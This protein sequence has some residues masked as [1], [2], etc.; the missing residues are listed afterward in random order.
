MPKSLSVVILK[1]LSSIAFN[2]CTPVSAQ[3]DT[4]TF[5]IPPYEIKEVEVIGKKNPDGFPE[6]GRMVTVIRRE[7][8]IAAPVQSLQ[9]LLESLFAVDIC[10]R[11]Q[12]G[13]QADLTIRGGSFDHVMILLNGVVIS[14][15]QTGHFNLDI[16]LDIDAIQRIE[17]LNGPS[18]RIYGSGALTGAI[19]II[20][21]PGPD[22]YG[23][24]SLIAGKY[25]YTRFG[26]TA[27]VE[28]GKLNN[29]ISLAHTGS[30]G[31]TD[32]TDFSVQQVY[33]TGQYC[34]QSNI[35]NLQAGFQ[36]KAFGANGFYSPRFPDQ[37][38]KNNNSIISLDMK[39]G[40]KVIFHS[41]AFW[42]RKQDHYVLQRDN[43]LFYQNYHRTHVFGSRLTGRF[44]ASKLASMAGIDLRSENIISTNLGFDNMHP[45]RVKGEDSLYY[46]KQ[47]SRS[48]FSWFQEHILDLGKLS[49]TGGYMVSWNSDYSTK[50]SF[51]PG[52]DISYTFPEA[53]RYYISINRT[54]R[55]PTF[56]DMFYSDPSHQ[57]NTSLEPDRMISFE[58]GIRADF[59]FIKASIALH[60][61]TGKNIIDWLWSFETNRY[62]PLNI[63][64]FIT[65]G[66][67]IHADVPLLKV[68]SPRFPVQRIAI[69]YSFLNVDKSIPD[70]VSKYYN[71]KHKL[72]FELR[73]R[74]IRNIFT[75]W[76]IG[77]QDRMGSFVQYNF[78]ENNY[79]TTT[80]KPFFIVDGNLSWE[81][82][83]FTF[84]I[85]ASNLFNTHYTDAGSVSQP[86]RWIKAGVKGNIAFNNKKTANDQ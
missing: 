43:P 52:I 33:Y 4:L 28:T 24:A 49:V 64:H 42:R 5:I 61:S 7:D 10:Q 63:D 73:G 59:S 76:Y 29:L 62:S 25:D 8:F 80:Y 17:V 79:F 9:D 50:P 32:N 47:Y 57:G 37:F 27:S 69:G 40:K 68:L 30:T 85:E 18:A 60:R 67:E 46:S 26:F 65:H 31:Y 66:I 2:S 83:Q 78:T 3:P 86:G 84:F 53:I 75:T 56:T 41:S 48:F 45:V 14:D 16:P 51:F 44:T 72:T 35:F 39:T 6:I 11:G 81:T 15:P 13:V 21:R 70:S 77:Y 36:Q 34:R 1:I 12:H 22:Y 71:L 19:N 23:K 58:G 55:F 82:K 38:E 74:I 20:A 54:L